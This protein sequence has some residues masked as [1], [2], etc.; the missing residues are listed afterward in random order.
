MVLLVA[1]DGVFRPKILLENS[2]VE[3]DAKQI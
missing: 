1:L 3:Q 2:C